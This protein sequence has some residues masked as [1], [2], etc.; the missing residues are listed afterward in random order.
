MIDVTT[1]GRSGRIHFRDGENAHTFDWEF[2]GRNVVVTI[3]VPRPAV[4]TTVTPWPLERRTEILTRMA[5]DVANQ[6]CAGCAIEVTDGWVNLLEPTPFGT[7]MHF[8]DLPGSRLMNSSPARD[9][10]TGGGMRAMAAA[11]AIIGGVGSVALMY[12]VGSRNP[13]WLLLLMFLGWVSAPFAALLWAIRLA[14]RLPERER[15]VLYALTI[16]IAAASLAEYT[17]VAFGPP[18]TKPAR[19]FLMV[20]VASWLVMAIAAAVARSMSRGHPPRS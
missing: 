5:T 3:Y 2:G 13:S 12:H 9:S 4:W 16:L 1:S 19:F 11:S 20:P 14:P 15:T 6:K 8:V 18:P 10:A 17:N 7:F